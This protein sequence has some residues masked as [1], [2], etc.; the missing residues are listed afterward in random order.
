ML[1]V[2]ICQKGPL[3]ME[4]DGCADLGSPCGAE[5]DT[6]ACCSGGKCVSVRGQMMCMPKGDACQP[7]YAVCGLN[8]SDLEVNCCSGTECQ[9]VLG[10]SVKRCINTNRCSGEFDACSVDGVYFGKCCGEALCVET[11]NGIGRCQ[12]ATSDRVCAVQGSLCGDGLIPTQCCDNLVCKD[13]MDGWSRCG[14]VAFEQCVPLYKLCRSPGNADGTCCEG[15]C[16][17]TGTQGMKT[18]LPD[19]SI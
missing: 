4:A 8:T 7:E 3:S 6:S 12:R 18:C 11:F 14:A 9:Q 1:G 15:Q 16:T 19:S 2:G 10:Q 13:S 5:A 17:E